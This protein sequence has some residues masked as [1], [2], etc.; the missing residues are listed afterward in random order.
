MAGTGGAVS[1]GVGS[2]VEVVLS[3]KSKSP[4]RASLLQN[5]Y[6]DSDIYSKK[7]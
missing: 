7:T 4:S 5:H 3:S 2:K 6:D 1:N